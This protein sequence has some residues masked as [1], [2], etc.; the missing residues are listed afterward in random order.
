MP[1]TTVYPELAMWLVGRAKQRLVGVEGQTRTVNEAEDVLDLRRLSVSLSKQMSSKGKLICMRRHQTGFESRGK[2]AD[3]NTILI[4]TW[5]G[6]I[7][8]F[9]IQ[10]NLL[11]VRYPSFAAKETQTLAEMWC[12]WCALYSHSARSASL[13]KHGALYHWSDR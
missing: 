8:V 7:L 5:A 12:G 6:A 1:R 9:A 13:T 10:Q 2:N 4:W 11:T 3:N